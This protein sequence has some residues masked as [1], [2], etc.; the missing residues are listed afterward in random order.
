LPDKPGLG[1]YTSQ[2]TASNV[3]SRLLTARET[4][5]IRKW[6][7]VGNR[8]EVHGWSKRGPRGKQKRWDVRTVALRL[9]DLP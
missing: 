8:F 4:A 9:E 7:E 1:L 3:Y 5:E 6:L 2:P